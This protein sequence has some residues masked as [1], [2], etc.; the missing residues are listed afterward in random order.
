MLRLP[1]WGALMQAAAIT[2]AAACMNMAEQQPI[3]NGVRALGC[4]VRWCVPP[5][6]TQPPVATV[7]H[8][9][10][11]HMLLTGMAAVAAAALACSSGQLPVWAGWCI[12]NQAES[13][14]QCGPWG[15]GHVLLPHAGDRCRPARR[16][17]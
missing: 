6:G 3:C 16:R 17:G 10:R 1:S 14:P 13:Q 8:L 7:N 9:M 12:A 15:V 11:S 4:A 2:S 5:V